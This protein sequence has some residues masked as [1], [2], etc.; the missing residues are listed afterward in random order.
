MVTL[1][2]S[3]AEMLLNLICR[4]SVWLKSSEDCGWVCFKWRCSSHV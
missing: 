2:F 1:C 3:A 4:I